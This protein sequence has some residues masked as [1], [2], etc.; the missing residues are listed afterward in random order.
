M[1]V[2][3]HI[4]VLK[5][6]LFFSSLNIQR[7][8]YLFSVYESSLTFLV[9]GLIC[10]D[11]LIAGVHNSAFSPIFF[12]LIDYKYQIS[13]K[14][15]ITQFIHRINFSLSLCCHFSNQQLKNVVMNN[16]FKHF[17]EHGLSISL[18]DRHKPTTKCRLNLKAN[19]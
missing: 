10:D 18:N 8:S 3:S 16:I 11:S 12:L 14:I 2:W 9:V 17:Q 15:S 7:T 4:F 19:L 5:A 6:T 1:Y 13:S